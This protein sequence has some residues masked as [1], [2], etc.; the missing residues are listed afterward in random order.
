MSV[1]V[2]G[3]TGFI[4]MNLAEDLGDKGYEVALLARKPP[5]QQIE[6]ALKDK[7]ERI[8]FVKGDVTDAEGLDKILNEY[9]VDTI[10]H[11]AVITPDAERERNESK[12]IA[13]VNYMG[14]IEMLEA[15][16]RNKVDKF[17]HLSSGAVYGHASFDDEWLDEEHTYPRPDALYGI[18]KFASEMAAVRY[19]QIF[20]MNI[21][22]ARVG[23]VFGP[24]E[25]YTGVR[26]TLSGPFFA[27]RF[28]VLGEEAVLPRPG[29]KD[30][31]YSRDIAKSLEAMIATDTFSYDVYNLSSG[32]VWTV[33]DWCE[34]LK[35]VFPKF[36]Y[37]IADDPSQANIDFFDDRDRNPLSIKRLIDDVG[38][39]PQYDLTASLED[40]M[41]WINGQDGFWINP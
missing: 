14:A 1:L 41:E 18:N 21:V 13:Q 17:I 5:V 16:K 8:H 39:T 25:R 34:Q 33:Q 20:D 32:Y 4:G 15:A 28:A 10:I 40:Y 11:A 9:N 35:S 37:R 7:K 23:G 22:V 36:E 3:G 30:W 38:Y 31:V 24:W 29:V 12:L 6:Q 26:D 2:T 19:R 27:T